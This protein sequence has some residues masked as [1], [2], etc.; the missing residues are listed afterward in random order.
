MELPPSLFDMAKRQ[1]IRNIDSKLAW[2]LCKLSVSADCVS[3]VLEDVGDVPYN[4]LQPILFHVANPAQL[5]KIEQ[6]SPHIAEQDGEI[7]LKYIKRD[8][9]NWDQKPHQPRD[10]KNWWKVYRKL[11]REDEEESAKQKEKLKAAL[12]ALRDEQESS[13]TKVTNRLVDPGKRKSRPSSY[14]YSRI[15]PPPKTQLVAGKKLTMM[16]GKG[17]LAQAKKEVKEAARQ[18]QSVLAKPSHLL[19]TVGRKPRAAPKDWLERMMPGQDAALEAPKPAQPTRI[20]APS[21]PLAT[22]AKSESSQQNSN[23]LAAREARLRALKDSRSAP[24]A[25]SA[26]S[27]SKPRPGSGSSASTR[28]ADQGFRAASA[29]GYKMPRLPPPVQ[30]SP[31]I[32][33]EKRKRD[34]D[35]LRST[36]RR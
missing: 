29:E 8:I 34:L 36:K 4:I 22:H 28:Y 15:G 30:V 27:T 5:H 1:I 13:A 3:L 7:W 31:K 9:Q 14:S 24:S 23:D 32:A 6:Q 35:C 21:R 10:P 19:S 11:K 25:S 20:F 18:R 16:T 12:D 2:L 17:V 26:V 33:G